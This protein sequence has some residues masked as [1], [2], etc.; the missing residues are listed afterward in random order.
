MRGGVGSLNGHGKSSTIGSR[1]VAVT[2]TFGRSQGQASTLIAMAHGCASF[3]L[4]GSAVLFGPRAAPGTV[5]DATAPTSASR[6]CCSPRAGPRRDSPRRRAS[7]D[8]A[9]LPGNLGAPV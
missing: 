1:S 9:S 3:E 4:Q 2:E 7:L 5:S 8:G 6:R